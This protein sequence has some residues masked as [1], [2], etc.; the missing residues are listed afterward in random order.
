MGSAIVVAISFFSALASAGPMMLITSP[1]IVF[2]R[3]L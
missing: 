2:S 3:F 1:G